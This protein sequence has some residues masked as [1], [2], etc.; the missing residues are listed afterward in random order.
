MTARRLEIL[1]AV[2]TPFDADG[3]VDESAARGLYERL[4]PVVDGLFVG[5]TTGEFP[6][7]DDAERT[8]LVPLAIAAVG[9][10]RV[11]ANVGAASARQA[12]GLARAAAEAGATRMAAI[13]PFYLAASIEGCIR[14]Y[15]SI[16]DA[17]P[18]VALYAYAFPDVAGTELPPDALGR[19][20]DVGV[21]GIKTSGAA[22]ARVEEYVATAPVG[23]AV[24]SGNDADMPRLAA[25]GAR[26]TVSGVSSVA[27][28]PFAR[29]S[30]AL[31]DGDDVAAARLQ[32]EVA[33]L[34]ALLGPSIARLKAGL[35]ALGMPMGECRMAIDA[36]DADLLARIHAV[37]SRS[38]GISA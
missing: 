23:F 37:T 36:P 15:A 31:A 17:A 4:S 16:K 25:C 32:R 2:P 8:R 3:S 12:V 19:L 6:A 34:V 5:G 18:D 14:Y 11:V 7:L 13:T 28:A 26:G 1:S 29:L 21:E 27:P 33:E 9:S 10:D 35:T 22:A 38:L 24:W 20:A 30:R